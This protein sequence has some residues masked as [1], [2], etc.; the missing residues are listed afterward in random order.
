M[1]QRCLGSSALRKYFILALLVIIRVFCLTPVDCDVYL[2][3]SAKYCIALLRK[4]RQNRAN[5]SQTWKWRPWESQN[6]YTTKDSVF[7]EWAEEAT[8]NTV[9]PIFSHFRQIGIGKTKLGRYDDGENEISRFSRVLCLAETGSREISWWTFG[10]PVFTFYQ[11]SNSRSFVNLASN[12]Q[13][14]VLDLTSFLMMIFHKKDN[15]SYVYDGTNILHTPFTC[16]SNHTSYVIA[17][18]RLRNPCT[19]SI[20]IPKIWGPSVWRLRG[21]LSPSSNRALFRRPLT[22]VSQLWARPFHSIL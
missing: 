19:F 10:R 3:S 22:K 13:T 7:V 9:G 12:Y 4:Y 16:L 2:P 8:K 20:T 1:W 6:S 18:G 14:Y 5:H 21:A 15:L 17:H 11:Q